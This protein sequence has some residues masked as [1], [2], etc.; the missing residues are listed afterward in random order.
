MWQNLDGSLWV[1]KTI[2]LEVKFVI[3][4]ENSSAETDGPWG[5]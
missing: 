4:S 3:L 1:N 5:P 2:I